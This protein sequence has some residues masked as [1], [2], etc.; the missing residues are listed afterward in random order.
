MSAYL[1]KNI[2]NGHEEE[3]D[4]SNSDVTFKQKE[5]GRDAPKK[6]KRLKSVTERKKPES[7]KKPA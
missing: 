7:K 4:N 3:K 1:A 6:D 2:A 5:Q